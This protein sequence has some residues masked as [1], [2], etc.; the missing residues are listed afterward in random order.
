MFEDK[1][2]FLL[3][4]IFVFLPS[5]PVLV[6]HLSYGAEPLW[7]TFAHSVTAASSVEMEENLMR[8]PLHCLMCYFTPAL[9][10]LN[11]GEQTSHRSTSLTLFFSTDGRV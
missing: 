1:R 7:E 10:T 2:H 11:L 9:V 8:T 6:H 5:S 4:I 3:K